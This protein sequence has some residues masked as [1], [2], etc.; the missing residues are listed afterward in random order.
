MIKRMMIALVAAAML[1]AMAI[2]A[3]AAHE[4]KDMKKA[5]DQWAM[6]FCEDVENSATATGGDANT[7]AENNAT[8]EQSNEVS[9]E[10]GSAVVA[11]DITQ[12]NDAEVDQTAVAIETGDATG[13]DAEAEAFACNAFNFRG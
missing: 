4:K 8:V 10:D 13:G 7:G 12:I 2:P 11:R 6:A 3:F 5:G 9:A 1:V